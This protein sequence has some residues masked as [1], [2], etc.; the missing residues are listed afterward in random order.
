MYLVSCDIQLKTT[1][2]TL[3]YLKISI[4]GFVEPGVT[5]NVEIN[6]KRCFKFV[7]VGYI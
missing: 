6:T 5:C 1:F 7:S 4:A 3:F 2:T